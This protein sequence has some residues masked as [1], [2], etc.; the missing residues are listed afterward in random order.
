MIT[1]FL[2]FS[3]YFQ[4]VV[5]RSEK[6][7]NPVEKTAKSKMHAKLEDQSLPKLASTYPQLM[8]RLPAVSVVKT[9]MLF[10]TMSG[11][12]P[13]KTSLRAGASQVGMPKAL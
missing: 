4:T 9:P 8:A 2:T 5:G 13:L 6:A 1:F 3:T 7:S 11:D 12:L 10:R